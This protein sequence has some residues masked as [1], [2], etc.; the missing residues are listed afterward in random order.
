LTLT[1]WTSAAVAAD[2]EKRK[3]GD[4]ERLYL[5]LGGYAV[6]MDSTVRLSGGGGVAADLD[7]ESIL[8][9]DDKRNTGRLDGYWR[10]APRHRLDF[11]Y[12]YSSR[13]GLRSL[14][15]GF[16]WG[17]VRYDVDAEVRSEFDSQY[18]KAAYRFAFIN[19]NRIEVGLS[20][21][22]ATFSLDT[23][24]EGEGTV[25]VD[26]QPTGPTA[27]QRR[28]GSVVAPVPNV[29]FYAGFKLVPSLVLRQSFEYFALSASEWSARY[30]EL[31]IA[32]DWEF[33]PHWAFGVG[34]DE[35][36]LK[37]NESD[38]TSLRVDSSFDGLVVFFSYSR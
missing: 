30:T 3:V 10:F 23:T 28:K 35:T 21:G 6:A 37:Y 26:G 1:L 27:V 34:W 19:D 25:L 8:G 12:F 18:L 15:E 16:D 14:A 22:L 36:T 13:N 7:L 33:V 29:G 31:R 38:E 20:A 11:A 9:L 2:A 5:A 4:P 32:L 17:G 24:I